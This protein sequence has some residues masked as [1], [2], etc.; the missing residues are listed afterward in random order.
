MMV[1]YCVFYDYYKLFLNRNCDHVVNFRKLGYVIK[2]GSYEINIECIKNFGNTIRCS[3]L[4]TYFE[5]KIE[6]KI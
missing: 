5:K 3:D 4:D 2:T 1:K 6:K